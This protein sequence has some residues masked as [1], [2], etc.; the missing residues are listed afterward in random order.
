MTDYEK[1][2]SIIKDKTEYTITEEYKKTIP[3]AFTSVTIQN[4][5]DDVIGYYGFYSSWVFDKDGNFLE[6]GHWE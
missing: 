4:S 6:V 1:L 2:I 3:N 5:N